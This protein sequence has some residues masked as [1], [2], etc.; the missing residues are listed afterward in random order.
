MTASAWRSMYESQ[1][2]VIITRTGT[3][4]AAR[5]RLIHGVAGG[6]AVPGML[7]AIRAVN[8]ESIRSVC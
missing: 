8:R 4:I 5:H 2:Q 7:V 1:E 6:G 3:H